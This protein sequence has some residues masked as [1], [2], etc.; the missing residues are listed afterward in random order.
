MHICEYTH[1]DLYKYK[2]MY[3]CKHKTHKTYMELF[4]QGIKS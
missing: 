3:I 2:Y 4:Q 1:M